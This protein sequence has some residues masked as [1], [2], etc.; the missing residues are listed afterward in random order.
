MGFFSNFTLTRKP[1]ELVI[2]DRQEAFFALLVCAA[3]ADGDIDKFENQRLL[4]CASNKSVLFGRDSAELLRK[5]TPLVEKNGAGYVLQKA[6]EL[7]SYEEKKEA[8]VCTVDIF[9]SNGV[10]HE[11][12]KLLLNEFAAELN[13]D[14]EWC[15]QAS[16]VIALLYN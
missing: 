16:N 14:T 8:F 10:I 7:L 1:E 9:C 15:Q 2:N 12:E 11:R 3:M 6:A 5:T 13:L 4:Q